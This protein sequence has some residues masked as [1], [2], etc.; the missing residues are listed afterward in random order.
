MKE[1]ELRLKFNKIV[2]NYC[3]KVSLD[4]WKSI[5]DKEYSKSKL[6][7][8]G[9]IVR[10]LVER[11]IKTFYTKLE[12]DFSY[13]TY[14]KVV[15]NRNEEYDLPIIPSPNLPNYI[16]INL[17]PSLCLFEGTN[18]SV[19]RGTDLQFQIYG[20]PY[21]DKKKNEYKFT[22]VK[23]N[24]SKYPKHENMLCFGKI[25]TNT[26]I[27][28]KFNLSFILEAYNDT[29]NKEDFFNNYFIKLAG[30]KD[31]QNQEESKC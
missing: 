8:D 3:N 26:E 1:L 25:L 16:S 6:E 4:D 7:I 10:S 30:T 5:F 11:A 17:Y 12:N 19:G 24:G 9:K 18:V 28:N 23:N 14:Y 15:E 27:L 20:S 31:L 29:S 22:P 13:D 21:L 2:E